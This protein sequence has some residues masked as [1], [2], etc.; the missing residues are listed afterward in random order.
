MSNKKIY[1]LCLLVIVQQTSGPITNLATHDDI[2]YLYLHTKYK[3]IMTASLY[4]ASSLTWVCFSA[5][6][7]HMK[8]HQGFNYER[9]GLSF[10]PEAGGSCESCKV[11]LVVG[12]DIQITSFVSLV[13][14]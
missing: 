5:L 9:Q 4:Q 2:Q 11:S 10:D 1:P 12:E 8:S 7:G 13:S 3:K 14:I 6:S